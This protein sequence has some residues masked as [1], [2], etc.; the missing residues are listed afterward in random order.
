MHTTHTITLKEAGN[1]FP[2]IGDLIELPYHAAVFEIVE[3]VRSGHITPSDR[4][5]GSDTM[6]VKACRRKIDYFND[7]YEAHDAEII[8]CK[9]TPDGWCHHEPHHW[10]ADRGDIDIERK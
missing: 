8:E 5:G 3:L 10:T 4:P 9:S 1:G 2:S 7:Q 6:Q